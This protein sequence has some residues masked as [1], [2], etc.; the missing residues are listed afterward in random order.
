MTLLQDQTWRTV[1]PN[2]KRML[3]VPL[4][5]LE[6]HGPHLP[7]DTDSVIAGNVARAIHAHV[8]FAD[9]A[10]VIPFGASDEHLDFPGTLSI[11][12]EAL[13]DLLVK[14]LVD[15]QRTWDAV[16]LVN[17]HGGNSTA[18]KAA[19]REARKR[20]VV[21]S[22]VGAV[23]EHGDAHAGRSE[24][25]LMLHLDPSRVRVGEMEAGNVAS[26]I[27]LM[28][29]LVSHGVRGVAEN[30]VL[31]DPRGANASEGE[32]IFEATVKNALQACATL[33]SAIPN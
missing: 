1:M 28:P 26:L 15:S 30:G 12:T 3:I 21:A 6:Q 10:P 16:L 23:D 27:S 17:G 29:D 22:V 20:N 13:C 11:G 25:S 8:D 33:G 18:L 32:R 7:L 5:S 31:G 19:L 4:G 24:T 14:L 9:L 2:S